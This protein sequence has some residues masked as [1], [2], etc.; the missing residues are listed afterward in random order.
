[1]AANSDGNAA[2]RAGIINSTSG[3]FLRYGFKKTSMDDLARAAGLS[4]QGLYLHFPTKEALFKQTVLQ[5]VEQT[6]AAGQA[7]LDRDEVRV[8]E[9]LLG[10]FE[11]LHGD[12]IGQ[13]ESEH[14]SELMATAAEL[15]GPVLKDLETRLLGDVARVLKSAGIAARWKDAGISAKDLADQLCATSL[16]LKHRVASR[17]QYRS[18]MELAIQMV[19]RGAPVR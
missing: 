5:I 4:R 13:P 14:M 12:K 6:R 17:D 8:E 9:R 1:M 15:V 11:A 10:A 7:A 2:R 16:G 19:C 3:E 18:G